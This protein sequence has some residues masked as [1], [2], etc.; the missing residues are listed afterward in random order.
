MLVVLS[1]PESMVMLSPIESS[2][3]PA[4][5]DSGQEAPGNLRAT[6]WVLSHIKA[7][8]LLNTTKITNLI[9]YIMID[10]CIIL[11]DTD[12]VSTSHSLS[13]MNSQRRIKI[14]F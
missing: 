12:N 6:S 9:S 8:N 1:V 7:P 4:L 11:E 2:S 13:A 10:D 3:V 14:E 5:G